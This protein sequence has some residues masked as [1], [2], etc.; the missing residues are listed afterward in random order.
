MVNR[1]TCVRMIASPTP[2]TDLLNFHVDCSN[3]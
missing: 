2:H 1:L 3:T